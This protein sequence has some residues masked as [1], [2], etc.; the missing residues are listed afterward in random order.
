MAQFCR[1]LVSASFSASSMMYAS[2]VNI[3]I[4]LGFVILSFMITAY[5]T[6]ESDFNASVYSWF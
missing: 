6:R 1:F 4:N 3:S 2:A 5:P